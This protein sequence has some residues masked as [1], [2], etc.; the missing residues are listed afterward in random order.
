MLK[1][2]PNDALKTFDEKLLYSRKLIK[3]S[4]NNDRRPNNDNDAD[5]RTDDNLTDRLDKFSDLISKE[6]IY[7]IPLRFLVDIGLVN[8]PIAFDTRFISTLLQD[9]NKL[10]ES[11]AKVTQYQSL[12]QK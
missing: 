4:G 6:T 12:T 1:H 2:M 11:N 5:N 7:K 8:F 10:F 9:L 3:L